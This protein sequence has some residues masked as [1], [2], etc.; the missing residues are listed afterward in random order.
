MG[1][2]K[3]RGAHRWPAS[4]RRGS[5]G[6]VPGPIVPS[7]AVLAAF[8]A[9]TA[10]CSGEVRIGGPEALSGADVARELRAEYDDREKASGI[11]LTALTCQEVEAEVD[12]TITCSGRN[13]KEIDLEL[14]GRITAT[15]GDGFDYS[16]RVARAFA[17][18][19]LFSDPLRPQ[20]ERMV[21]RQVRDVTC[22]VRVLIREGGRF[23]CQVAFA[24]R[25]TF[26][27]DIRQTDDSGSFTWGLRRAPGVVT[28]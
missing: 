17:P 14:S 2:R 18:G 9:L 22:P 16:W 21:R 27:A 4:R 24:D 28:G 12:A 13:S 6:P 5:V 7:I 11:T 20:I 10:G 8:A 19:S 23:R 26:T 25:A 3:P 1:P 15:D